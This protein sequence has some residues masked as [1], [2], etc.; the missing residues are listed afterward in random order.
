MVRDTAEL[1]ISRGGIGLRSATRTGQFAPLAALA[2]ALNSRLH[3]VFNTR[4]RL[5]D[6]RFQGSATTWQA[7]TA[8][9]PTESCP[10]GARHCYMYHHLKRTVIA[11]DDTWGTHADADEYPFPRDADEFLREVHTHKYLPEL[12]AG[13]AG[14]TVTVQRRMAQWVQ[15]RLQARNLAQAYSPDDKKRLRSQGGTAGMAFISMIPGCNRDR[16]T[17]E[18]FRD[19]LREVTGVPSDTFVDG[20]FVGTKHPV[21][22]HTAPREC[23]HCSQPDRPV[24]LTRTHAGRCRHTGALTRVHNAVQKAVF[25]ALRAHQVRSVEWEPRDLNRGVDGSAGPDIEISDNR[26]GRG[27]IDVTV[28]DNRVATYDGDGTA[29]RTG[30]AADKAEERKNASA[31]AD[32]ARAG[33]QQYVGAAIETS[34]H[35]GPGMRALFTRM[36]RHVKDP[37][38]NA[39]TWTLAENDV[40]ALTPQYDNPLWSAPTITEYHVQ[41]VSA[42]MRR[43]LWH[44]RR[45]TL[46]ESLTPFA[47]RGGGTVNYGSTRAT[48]TVRTS[49]TSTQGSTTTPRPAETAATATG[50]TRP[51]PSAAAAAP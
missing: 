40:V 46:T 31:D 26:F 49:S 12:G 20:R 3:H 10:V 7:A 17:D 34:G 5:Q 33:G 39:Q 11:L 45:H 27:Y 9:N 24:L 13:V 19:E 48:S 22:P 32:E 35:F 14:S 51:T 38:R 42:D 15:D 2:D 23:P 29:N 43:E 1:S 4:R 37:G 41:C 44:A 18:Q 6:P 50:T 16:F 28:V 36:W 47:R 25:R 8:D 21:P 30:V